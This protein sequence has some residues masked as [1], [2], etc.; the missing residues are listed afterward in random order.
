MPP[1]S[2]SMAASDSR[3][4][5][6]GAATISTRVKT[7]SSWRHASE[8]T[9]SGRWP[10]TRA[11]DPEL[12]SHALPWCEP[13]HPWR[14]TPHDRTPRHDY[15]RPG[16]RGAGLGTGG[17]HQSQDAVELLTRDVQDG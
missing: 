2:R 4:S 10:G 8:T 3:S 5:V 15:A 12:P 9:R 7:P 16:R 13:T 1:P 6:G 14:D 17:A 11:R